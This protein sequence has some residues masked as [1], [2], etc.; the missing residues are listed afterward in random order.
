MILQSW[1]WQ[2]LPGVH[3]LEISSHLAPKQ[4]RQQHSAAETETEGE[5]VAVAVAASFPGTSPRLLLINHNERKRKSDRLEQF[6]Q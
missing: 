6:R 5:A 2:D 1:F 3:F 4:K